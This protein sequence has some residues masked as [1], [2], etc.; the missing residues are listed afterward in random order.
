MNIDF[1]NE[2]KKYI[3]GKRYTHSLAV[4]KECESLASIFKLD[5]C[6]T[7]RLTAAAY[8]HDITKELD[9]D[10]QLKLCDKYGIPY[11]DAD[12]LAPKT[13]HAKT[14]AALARDK[15]PDI[16]DD[17]VCGCIRWHTTGRAGMS[18]P[19]SLLYL[20]DY[21][22]PTRTFDDCIKLREYFYSRL[23]GSDPAA[24][25]LDTL[26]LSFDMTISDLISNGKLIDNDTIACR[27]S[28]LMKR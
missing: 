23:D 10:A 18:L 22:E 3:G 4:E 2:I 24:L 20:A 12:C 16:A 6:D 7:E 5:K 19:E 14:A 21:I 8:L 9:L 28:L 1:E 25:L 27:N 26:I 15:Y 13:F 11:T 17:F